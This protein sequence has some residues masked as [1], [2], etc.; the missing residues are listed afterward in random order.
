MSR[1][2]PPMVGGMIAS[3]V[4]TLAVIPAIYALVKEW[5]FRRRAAKAARERATAGEQAEVAPMQCN[6][7]V[8]GLTVPS[9]HKLR[10]CATSGEGRGQGPN[11]VTPSKHDNSLGGISCT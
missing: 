5:P 7:G 9:S 2:A 3:T 1:I 4:L 8:I 6:A 10:Q 11:Q